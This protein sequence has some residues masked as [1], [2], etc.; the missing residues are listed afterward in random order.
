M[1]LIND[2]GLR[3]NSGVQIPPQVQNLQLQYQGVTAFTADGALPFNGPPDNSWT[4]PFP[5]TSVISWNTVI[6]DS[7]D[8]FREDN[9]SGTYNQIGTAVLPPYVDATAAISVNPTAGA[10]P[11]YYPSNS[12]RYKVRARNSAGIGPFSAVNT[13]VVYQN[14]TFN[15]SGDYSFDLAVN[16]QDTSGGPQGGIADIRCD[17]LAP[18]GGFQPHSGGNTVQWNHWQGGYDYLRF[19]LKLGTPGLFFEFYALRA[20]D[21]GIYNSS[22]I[23]YSN[24]LQ[25]F[26]PPE[27][28]NWATYIIALPTYLTDYGPSGTSGPVI[29]YAGYKWAVHEKSGAATGTWYMDNIMYYS[30]VTPPSTPTGLAATPVSST[31]IDLTWTASTDI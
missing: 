25:T 11:Q 5:G 8:I 18:F 3:I 22:G 10:G 23:T 14:G 9:R 7:Y 15:Y 4:P 12:Y 24:F 19:D 13:F 27:S 1:F 29:Q 17:L 31:E 2:T 6:A 20:G 30:D 16:Y 28:T 26:G 21:V